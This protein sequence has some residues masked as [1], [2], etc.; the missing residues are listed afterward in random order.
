VADDQLDFT[1]FGK[2]DRLRVSIDCPPEEA[3]THQADKAEVDI[4]NIVRRGVPAVPPDLRAQFVDV[5]D[6]QDL[7]ATLDTAREAMR[8]FG[9][10]PSNIRKLVKNDPVQLLELMDDPSKE[11]AEKRVAM[12]LEEPPGPRA[13]EVTPPSQPALPPP[14]PAAPPGSGTPET[15]A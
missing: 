2:G 4:N 5:S 14:A 8:V 3:R 6:A 10:L 1:H 13:P 9:E 11:A 7:K 15:G 12:G